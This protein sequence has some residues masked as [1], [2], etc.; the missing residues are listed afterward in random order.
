MHRVLVSA[1]LLGERV[2]HNGE[3]RQSH[4]RIL[5]RWLREGTTCACTPIA[6]HYFEEMEV[7]L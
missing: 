6:L 5:H 3:H 7:I 1:C 2:R 4:D